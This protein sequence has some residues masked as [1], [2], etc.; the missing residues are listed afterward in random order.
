MQVVYVGDEVAV[1]IFGLTFVPGVPV[2]VSDPHA[3]AKLSKHPQFA[4]QEDTAPVVKNEK[5]P[6]K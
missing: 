2:S 3:E 4:V 1:Y 5:K 6:K